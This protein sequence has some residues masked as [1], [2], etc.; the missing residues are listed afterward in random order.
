LQIPTK[1]LLTAKN[2]KITQ[3]TRRKPLSISLRPSR[4]L[5]DLRG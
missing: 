4:H 5:C 2:A 1:N 3:R